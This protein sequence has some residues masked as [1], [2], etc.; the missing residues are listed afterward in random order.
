MDGPAQAKQANS[1]FLCLFVHFSPTMQGAYL[2]WSKLTLLILSMPILISSG[3]MLT[4]TPRN[5]VLLD[6]SSVKLTH[7]TNH[8]MYQLFSNLRP[9]GQTSPQNSGP[10]YL[11]AHKS[12]DHFPP[13][14]QQIPDGIN[15]L[16][17]KSPLPRN[18]TTQRP[19]Q[20]TLK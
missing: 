3:N 18:G 2:H 6:L 17:H 5:N 15:Y 11:T 7:K 19:H 16:P 20:K 14:S 13:Q 4:G 8:H 12:L 10:R 1:P 9:P